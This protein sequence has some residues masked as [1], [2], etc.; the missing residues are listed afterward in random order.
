MD[1][2][3]SYSCSPC[4]CPPPLKQCLR[5]AC[6]E[7]LQRNLTPLEKHYV[8]E[9][10]Q[11]RAA[12]A[13]AEDQ[14]MRHNLTAPA[15]SAVSHVPVDDWVPPPSSNTGPDHSAGSKGG[16]GMKLQAVADSSLGDFD[17]ES[18]NPSGGGGDRRRKRR[19]L[20]AVEED[21]AG[22]GDPGRLVKTVVQQRSVV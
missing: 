19:V 5:N 6:E 13:A 7:A 3:P 16:K 12:A 10:L 9:A 20:E 21:D 11:R 4:L 14:P 1:E 17:G 18:S 2:S 15:R 8:K 22:A